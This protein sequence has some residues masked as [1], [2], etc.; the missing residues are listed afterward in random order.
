MPG[1]L[2]VID[3]TTVLAQYGP[4]RL[5]I[6]AWTARGPDIDLAVAAGRFS[7]SLLPRLLPSRD[8]FRRERWES[9]DV[10]DDQEE[11]LLNEMIRAV[12]R[13]DH[14]GLGPMATVA[15]TV[16]EA[17]A[18]YC[19]DNGATKAIVENGGDLSLW[20]DPGQQAAVGVRMGVDAA[21]P[22][23]RFVLSGDRRSLWGVCSSGMGGR[24]L[25]RGIA[26]TAM[27]IAASTPVADAAATAMGNECRV[28]SPAVHQVPA[29]T[30][31]PDTDIAGLMVT[32]SVGDLAPDEI[33][34][35][36][37]AAVVYADRLVRRDVLLGALAAVRGVVGI[38]QGFA[39][40]V[41]ILTAIAE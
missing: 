34:T 3:E 29:E 33:R 1:E 8:L 25:T 16:A 26:D 37:D 28:D 40:R 4:I 17:V 6:Q 11:P 7:Y 21:V 2:A 14:D 23:H 30:L 32:E 15:G 9:G 35:A 38:T 31:R 22:S 5:T 13:V 39:D 41:G 20:L 10:S 18:L 12:R 36:V 24:S 27:C 19:R